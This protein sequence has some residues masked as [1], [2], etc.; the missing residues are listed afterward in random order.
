V[1]RYA[2]GNGNDCGVWFSPVGNIGAS[3]CVYAW[4]RVG[5]RCGVLDG[6]CKL[7]VSDINSDLS[8]MDSATPP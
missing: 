7:S 6:C 1:R 8:C 3:V 5:A 2:D 4:V